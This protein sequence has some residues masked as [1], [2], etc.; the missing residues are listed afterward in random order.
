MRIEDWLGEDN[1]SNDEAY[2]K[3][4]SI[5]NQI[6]NIFTM[7]GDVYVIA[8]MLYSINNVK[9]NLMY[10][11]NNSSISDK[12]MMM[13]AMLYNSHQS[14]EEMNQYIQMIEG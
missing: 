1:A 4:N 5:V 3:Y 12:D 10:L 8:N 7:N 13:L 14:L 2:F 9:R 6:N 11:V